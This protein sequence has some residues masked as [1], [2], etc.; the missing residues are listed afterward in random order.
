MKFILIWELTGLCKINN[1]LVGS[2]I[3]MER[4]DPILMD[5]AGNTSL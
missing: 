2:G 4:Q 5:F 3:K 1:M